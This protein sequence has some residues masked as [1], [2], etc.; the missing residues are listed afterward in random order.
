[1][2]ASQR[3]GSA[4]RIGARVAVKDRA[5]VPTTSSTQHLQAS[6][7]LTRLLA[8]GSRRLEARMATEEMLSALRT[9]LQFLA[10]DPD[11]SSRAFARILLG[12]L[13]NTELH[14]HALD[15]DDAL[16]RLGF[17]R[18]RDGGEPEPIYVDESG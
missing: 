5:V 11:D 2:S 15:A 16:V 13:W 7:A 8:A 10:E 17:A 4:T 14:L 3:S 9:T 1:M 12:T 18:H 6:R